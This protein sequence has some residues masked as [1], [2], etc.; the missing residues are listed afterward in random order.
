MT[1]TLDTAHS[2]VG[3]AVRH[4][5]LS[6]VRGSFQT[7][8]LEDVN[9]D[10]ANPTAARGHVVIDIAS[11][12]TGDPKRDGHLVS[13]DFFEAAK[14]P[15]MTFAAR[16]VDGSGDRYKVTGDLTIKDVTRSVT[17]DAEYLGAA[18]DPYGNHKAGVSLTGSISRGDFG[19]KW[20]VPLD[21]DRLLVGDKV[22]LEIDLQLLEQAAP[23]AAGAAG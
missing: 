22:K 2:Q 21:G 5:G 8:R 1:W 6:T 15:T 11:V 20:N 4:M 16:S 10:A 14:H 9:F 3:F 19:L 23:V 7:V 18:N 17:L 13:P 12:S